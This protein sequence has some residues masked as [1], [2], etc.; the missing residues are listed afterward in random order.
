M[1]SYSFERMIKKEY[2]KVK[3]QKNEQSATISSL[4]E[5]TSKEKE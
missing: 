4:L 2:H 1:F 5:E 3:V